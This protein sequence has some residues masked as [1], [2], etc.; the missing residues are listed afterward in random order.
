MNP[1]RLK[2]ARKRR[3]LTQT[4]LAEQVGVTQ[5]VIGQYERGEKRPGVD[6]LQ[7]LATVLEVNLPWLLGEHIEETVDEYN[8]AQEKRSRRAAILADYNAPP[9]VRELASHQEL[10]TSLNITEAE[11][12]ALHSLVPPGDLSMD[13]YLSVLFALRAGIRT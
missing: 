5:S 4:Q 1:S 11:W 9:G 7:K 2:S 10:Y 12:H 8:Q 6:I 13:G 3:G